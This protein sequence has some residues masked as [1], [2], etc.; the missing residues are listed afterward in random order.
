MSQLVKVTIIPNDFFKHLQQLTPSRDSET[1]FKEWAASEKGKEYLNI[2][3][4]SKEG[5]RKVAAFNDI[6]ETDWDLEPQVIY[7]NLLMAV[8]KKG[9]FGGWYISPIEGYH[10]FVGSAISVLCGP[11]DLTTGILTPHKLTSKHFK[12]VGVGEK[13]IHISEEDFRNLIFDSV[14]E[15]NVKEDPVSPLFRYYKEIGMNAGEMA[16]H[17][18][19]CSQAISTGKRGSVTRC[20]WADLGSMMAN[21]IASITIEQASC[22]ADFS[23]T[24]NPTYNLT[25][26]VHVGETMSQEFPMC[27]LLE[28]DV[29]V[30]YLQSPFSQETYEAAKNHL[31]FKRYDDKYHFDCKFGNEGTLGRCKDDYQDFIKAGEL[32]EDIGFPFI[33]SYLSLAEDIGDNFAMK[34]RLT[35][36]TVNGAI[37]APRIISRL[38]CEMS[39][40]SQTDA[41]AHPE[42]LELIRFYLTFYNNSNHSLAMLH[43]HDAWSTYLKKGQGKTICD[44]DGGACII[45]C[46][47]YIISIF[48]A[49]ISV[50]IE[51]TYGQGWKVRK[52]KLSDIATLFQTAFSS[53]GTSKAGRNVE[54]V[55]RILCEYF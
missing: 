39:E 9:P 45:G 26:K 5:L 28:A 16:Y 18:R 20:C 13:R 36:D 50:G 6:T 12:D 4:F 7:K 3:A 10:R 52:E 17:H 22:R 38:F 44:G 48:N 8:L 40:L 55:M 15:R 30:K 37:L 35:P 34:S 46:T 32:P 47:F 42:R 23:E 49:A 29:Y 24:V 14:F 41:L 53:I 19:V 2:D 25:S 54:D 51:E 11:I 31:R 1:G 33:G 27:N 21:I 43:L